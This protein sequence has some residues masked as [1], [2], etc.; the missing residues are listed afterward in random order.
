MQNIV[1]LLL[2]PLVDHT[3]RDFFPLVL[4]PG[5]DE[6]GNLLATRSPADGTDFPSK[7]LRSR[8]HTQSFFI[9]RPL[10]RM[11]R[12]L[13]DRKNLLEPEVLSPVPER[14]PRRSPS[15]SAS[16]I[17]QGRPAR[18]D[19][20]PGDP[21]LPTS[22]A[23]PKSPRGRRQTGHHG[24]RTGSNELAESLPVFV[25]D[26][27]GAAPRLSSSVFR[28]QYHGQPS[29]SQPYCLR[30]QMG[31][32]SVRFAAQPPGRRRRPFGILPLLR[33]KGLRGSY[34]AKKQ[35]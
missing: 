16:G 22:R 11:A 34:A 6:F 30:N 21:C 1:A 10:S 7:G 8:R 23:S 2:G 27:S 3:L 19:R 4:R 29:S 12:S 28:F 24:R 35:D 26:R 14:W 5:R 13:H 17:I 18:L 31:L 25:S 9:V 20:R 15:P 32:R 33:P